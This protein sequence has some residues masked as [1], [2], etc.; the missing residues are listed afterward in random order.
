MD[1]ASRSGDA[2][3]KD[4]VARYE[5]KPILQATTPMP[6]HASIVSACV[7]V[8]VIFLTVTDCPGCCWFDGNLTVDQQW[9]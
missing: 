1:G 3:L 8:G 7:C 5:P 6:R 2:Y 9:T 4:L